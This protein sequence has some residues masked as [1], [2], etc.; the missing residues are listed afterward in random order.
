MG[1]YSFKSSGKTQEQ[2]LVEQLTS[3]TVPIGIMTPL[4]LGYGDQAEILATHSSLAD[5][6][7]DNL[8]NLL[9]TNWGERV[10]SYDFG[11]NLRPLMSDLVSLDDFDSKTIERISSAVN[12]WMPYVSLEDFISVTDHTDNKNTAIIRLTVTYSVIALN[13]KTRALELVLYAM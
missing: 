3:A 5:Q 11:A 6:V 13:V 8:R 12:R 9:M 10:G 4:R 7:H 1:S 2:K